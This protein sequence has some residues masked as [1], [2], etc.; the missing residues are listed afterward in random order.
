MAKTM[1]LAIELATEHI[2][3]QE[4]MI[5]EEADTSK[6]IDEYVQTALDTLYIE[7]EHENDH[8]PF[9]KVQLHQ[10][11]DKVNDNMSRYIIDFYLVSLE[12]WKESEISRKLRKIIPKHATIISERLIRSL[13]TLKR[14]PVCTDGLWEDEEPGC[15]HI[16]GS[17]YI[18]KFL[19]WW[20]IFPKT[21]WAFFDLIYQMYTFDVSH[22]GFLTKLI[23]F[24]TIPLNGML[25]MMFLAQFNVPLLGEFHYGSA[26][27]VNSALIFFA[28]LAIIYIIAGFLRKCWLWG[29]SMVVVLGFL[30]ISGNMWY[31][32]F[33]IGDQTWYNPTT[34]GTNPLIWSYIVS[35]IQATSHVILPQIPPN[36]TGNLPT[37]KN[38]S[39]LYIFL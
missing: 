24:F 32:D 26:F 20:L 25:T 6:S 29:F 35:L 39:I 28:F 2:F 23:H 15:A 21:Q 9:Y 37:R 8:G 13:H 17:N 10:N 30:T 14:N 16:K 18:T 3:S 38:S 34:Y 27:A 33:R 12:N 11:K 4:I 1:N 36:I 19:N 5:K 7:R 31:Y 22:Q